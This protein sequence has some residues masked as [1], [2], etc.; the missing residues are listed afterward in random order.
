MNLRRVGTT[1]SLINGACVTDRPSKSLAFTRL[2]ESRNF[3]FV[4]ERPRNPPQR[5]T[6]LADAR[7]PG[8][9]PYAILLFSAPVKTSPPCHLSLS[10]RKPTRVATCRLRAQTMVRLMS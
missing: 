3:H 4:T 2:R 5:A 10:S 6:S 9:V 1:H 7:S 8:H